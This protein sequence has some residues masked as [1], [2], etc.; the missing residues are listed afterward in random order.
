M[1]KPGHIPMLVW[2]DEDDSFEC[3]GAIPG[4]S[5]I[6][7]LSKT[8]PTKGKYAGGV[9]LRLYFGIGVGIAFTKTQ[10]KKLL[11]GNTFKGATRMFESPSSALSGSQLPPQQRREAKAA[12]ICEQVDKK[13]KRKMEILRLESFNTSKLARIEGSRALAADKHMKCKS[14]PPTKLTFDDAASKVIAHAKSPS[15]VVGCVPCG[16]DNSPSRK[17]NFISVK[18]EL[19]EFYTVG[20]DGIVKSWSGPLEC[21]NMTGWRRVRGGFIRPSPDYPCQGMA[22]REPSTKFEWKPGMKDFIKGFLKNHNASSAPCEHISNQLMLDGRWSDLDCPSKSQVKNYVQS[23]FTQKK[24][25]AE[26][27]LSRAGKRSYNGFSE[28]WLKNEVVHR[29]LK[30]GRNRSAGCI[31]LL[32]RHDDDHSESLSKFHCTPD[33]EAES[34]G[35]KL[36]G[37]TAF[38]KSIEDPRRDVADGD[39]IPLLEWYI[40]ECAYQHVEVG[41][42]VRETGMAKLLYDHYI[43]HNGKVKRHD[44]DHTVDGDPAHKLGDKVEV[45]WKKNWYPAVVIKCYKNHTWDVRYPAGADQVFCKRLPIALLRVS[46]K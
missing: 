2:H 26:H 44:G 35:K 4:I 8:Y 14:C 27:A 22:I 15:V 38:K 29:G 34:N 42:K 16:D 21:Y 20:D 43:H 23:Y 36:L 46:S 32:E 33:R 5:V 1:A 17:L 39:F 13:K 37:F 10:V 40:K 41:K 24:K 9:I 31:R 30:V 6:N 11:G 3:N 25:S 18:D 7:S 19:E 12:K 28:K 45:L